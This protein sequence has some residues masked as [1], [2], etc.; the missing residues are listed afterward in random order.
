MGFFDKIDVSGG[1]IIKKVQHSSSFLQSRCMPFLSPNQ[2][3]QATE[4][5]FT[6]QWRVLEPGLVTA[7]DIRL[8][9]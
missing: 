8:G 9:S 6:Q 7:Y 2:H 3:S 4:G 5:N 1:N